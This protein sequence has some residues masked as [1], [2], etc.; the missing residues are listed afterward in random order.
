MSARASA[1]SESERANPP[2]LPGW[3]RSRYSHHP[4]GNPPK[5]LVFGM[6]VLEC[7]TPLFVPPVIEPA[8]H[9]RLQAVDLGFQSGVPSDLTPPPQSV[10]KAY[11]VLNADLYQ[12]PG[13]VTWATFGSRCHLSLNDGAGEILNTCVYCYPIVQLQMERNMIFQVSLEVG[14][15]SASEISSIRCVKK[16]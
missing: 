14:P 11:F 2:W 7:G 15:T 1:F 3:R 10:L 4:L 5:R 12:I 6:E 9:K 13:D 16:G 8:G